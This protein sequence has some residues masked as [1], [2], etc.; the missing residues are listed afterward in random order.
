MTAV[1][2]NQSTVD[3]EERYSIA[4][5]TS[6]SYRERLYLVQIKS[7]LTRAGIYGD[8]ANYTRD[9]MILPL[10]RPEPHEKQD[11][12]EDECEDHIAPGRN[13][14]RVSLA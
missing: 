5:W 13:S 3:V 1:T 4:L 9:D 8:R 6:H 7:L 14:L 2:A 10:V 12:H 11:L